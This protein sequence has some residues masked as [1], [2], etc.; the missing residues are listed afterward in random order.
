MLQIRTLVIL[1]GDVRTGLLVCNHPQYGRHD[2]PSGL[3]VVIYTDEDLDNPLLEFAVSIGAI[4]LLQERLQVL[5][6]VKPWSTNAHRRPCWDVT[7]GEDAIGILP[8]PS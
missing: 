7:G 4:G 6:V 1:Q 3:H 2:A 5:I 8:D